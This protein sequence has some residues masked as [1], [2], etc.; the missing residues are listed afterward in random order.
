MSEDHDLTGCEDGERQ[1][2]DVDMTHRRPVPCSDVKLSRQ[3]C[4]FIPQMNQKLK[5]PGNHFS[6]H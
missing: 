6:I 5:F 1:A 4:G 3:S 2:V